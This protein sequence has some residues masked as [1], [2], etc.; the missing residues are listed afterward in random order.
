[1]TAREIGQPP[2]PEGA[3]SVEELTD[4]LLLLQAWV[5]MSFREVVR[6]RADR[7]V[8]ELPVLNTV[9]RCFQPGRARLDVDLVVD[10]ATVLLGDSAAA[11]RW[12]Q[13]C[14]VVAGLGSAAAI[15][16]VAD[17]WPDDLASFAGR[18]NDLARIVEPV[19]GKRFR[20]TI[21]AI[22]GMPGVGKTRFAVRAGHL[23]M[24]RGL[25]TDLRLAVDLCGYDPDRPPADPGAV[26]EGFLRRL[27]LS[28]NQIQHLGVDERAARYRQLFARRTVPGAGC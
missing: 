11:E 15:V 7:G 24:A 25:A 3:S 4:R 23:L 2:G 5:G 14:W 26:L 17:V 27:G 10:I 6:A 12:R 16:S 1:M 9:Y 22:A 13:A 19:N 21:W 8:P 28:G 20:T 18:H